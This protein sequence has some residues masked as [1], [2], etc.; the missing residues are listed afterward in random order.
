MGLIGGALG[1]KLL[2]TISS[3][4]ETGYCDGS[5]YRDRSKLEA[6]LGPGI[7]R[8]L[9]G[10]VVI[11]FGCGSG[12]EAIEVARRGAAKVIGVDNR[13]NALSEAREAARRAGVSDRCLFTTTADEKA[14]VVL[15]IDAFEH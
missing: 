12:S 15:S 8:E 13:E 5:A 3:D 10:K 4:G 9:E 11:D 14:D 6:L 1:Y 7:W 2:R